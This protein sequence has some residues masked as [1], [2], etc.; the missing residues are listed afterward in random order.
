MLW[1]CS[2]PSCSGS[3]CHSRSSPLEGE[4][5]PT[6]VFCVEGE[7]ILSRR[8]GTSQDQ[9]L[10]FNCGKT[11]TINMAIN[12]SERDR[13]LSGHFVTWLMMI[14]LSLNSLLTRNKIAGGNFSRG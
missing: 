6:D 14:P 1:M 2:P 5:S 3:S 4:F 11:E 10:S 9:V 7:R 13:K 12:L 8:L